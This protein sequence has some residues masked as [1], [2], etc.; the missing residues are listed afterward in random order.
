MRKTALACL[1]MVTAMFGTADA[2]SAQAA[3]TV[4][5]GGGVELAV[6]ETGH[7]DGSPILLIHGFLGSHLS[8]SEQLSGSL[9]E[10]FRIVALELRGHG[11]S[12]KPLDAES[13]T[14]PAMWAEDVAAVIR[15]LDLDR[16]VLVGWS[17]GGFA[18]ADY[19][20]DHG[21]EEIGGIVTVGS[22]SALGTDEASQ[23]VDERFLDI[24]GD[25]LSPDL[26]TR[27]YATRRFLPMVTAEPMAVDAFE[28][29]L[30]VAMMVPPEVRQAMFSRS[31]DNADVFGQVSV[32]ALVVQGEADRIVR[33]RAADLLAD[34]VP[35]TRELRFDD[36]GHAPF[37][38][39]PER[40]DAAL[41][42]FVREARARR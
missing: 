40:F 36:T 20:R 1:A 28:N 33:P 25:L 5:G 34:L 35:G 16:P 9:S 22:T 3:Q 15:Q 19:L 26:R 17:Y 30:A 12:D 27:V 14:D 6:Y 29:A 39:D 37:L 2:G 18:I 41:A 32:P 4:T 38:E 13:Y 42:G 24:V 7:L 11:A 10:E 21:D 23:L 31:F 8:W